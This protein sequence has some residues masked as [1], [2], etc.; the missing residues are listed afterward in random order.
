MIDSIMLLIDFPV[1]KP[2]DCMHDLTQQLRDPFATRESN[3]LIR[4]SHFIT[5]DGSLCKLLDRLWEQ[6][7]S[8]WEEPLHQLRHGERNLHA[9]LEVNI[10]KW[11]YQIF[12]S[13]EPI[14]LFLRA[15][16]AII[17]NGQISPWWAKGHHMSN[18]V[19]MSSNWL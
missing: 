6:S 10:Y 19:T 13:K 11:K 5:A 15:R 3:V 9:E 12:T 17:N 4:V 8:A 16:L 1:N 14:D 18:K 7:D 2:Q